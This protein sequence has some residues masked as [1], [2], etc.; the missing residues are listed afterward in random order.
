MHRE[1]I[2]AATV[3]APAEA[4]RSLQGA[5][6]PPELDGRGHDAQ[7][8]LSEVVSN[9][10]RHG[11][12]QASDTLLVVIDADE[13]H[14]RV[15]VE[16]PSPAKPVEVVAHPLPERAGEGGYGLHIVERIADIW[17]HEEGPPGRV[18]FEFRRDVGGA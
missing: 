4:R 11:R 10:V 3:N 17:G 8:V 5:I 7:L 16:Q 18:W 14:L 1:V 13:E 6:P 12:L 9:A 15:Q 2:L